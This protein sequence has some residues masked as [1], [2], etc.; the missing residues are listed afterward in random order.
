MSAWDTS[1]VASLVSYLIV[2]A[3]EKKRGRRE[4]GKE[5]E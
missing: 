5:I 4:E 3:I 1:R 2:E